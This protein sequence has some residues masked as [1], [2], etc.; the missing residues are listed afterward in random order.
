M[1]IIQLNGGLG[2]QMFQYAMGRFLSLK[3]NT[4]LKLDITCFGLQSK[5]K[6]L[7]NELNIAA[8]IATEDEIY[9]TRNFSKN[10]ILRKLFTIYQK[11]LPYW[12]RSQIIEKNPG[13]ADLKVLRCPKTC[14]LSGY[15]QSE[16]YFLTITDTLKN[17]LKLI[18][19]LPVSLQKFKKEIFDNPGS[20]SVHVRRGD[21]VSEVTNH[22]VCPI[23]YYQEAIALILQKIPR[24]HF[25]FFSDDIQWTKDNIRLEVPCTY[26][27]PSGNDVWD[28]ELMKNCRSHINANSSFSWWG[29]WLGERTNSLVIVPNKW[30][31][32]RPFPEDRIPGR[33]KKI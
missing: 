23:S 31:V 12:K 32:D 7:L 22:W 24:P 5:R 21:Y 28:L 33:W 17:E 14:Y 4:P 29:A 3:H 26:I 2:N 25:Y 20:V 16:K 13:I 30:F 27:N 18:N 9:L 1:I 15:W 11:N 19:E 10:R 8:Q 6:F